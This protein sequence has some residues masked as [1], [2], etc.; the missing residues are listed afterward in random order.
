MILLCSGGLDSLAAW[1]LLGCS[2]VRFDLGTPPSE[3]EGSAVR[4]FGLAYDL[5]YVESS[6]LRLAEELPGGFNPYRNLLLILAAA[7]LD[8]HVAIAQVAEWAPDKNPRAYRRL[9]GLMNQSMHGS[10]A[11]VGQRCRIDAPFASITKGQLL[12]RYGERF[13]R[14]ATIAL[15]HSSWSCYRN[16][17]IHCGECQGCS[18]RYQAEHVADLHITPYLEQPDPLPRGNTIDALRW[19]RDGSRIGL[20]RRVIE[21]ITLAREARA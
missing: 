6:A 15:L 14:S 10:L 7:R 12:E 2:A 21:T 5:D 13:G 17:P 1:R 8:P 20:A 18:S 16:E 4:G 19:L 3:R 11:G 9:A